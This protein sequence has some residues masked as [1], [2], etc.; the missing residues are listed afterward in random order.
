MLSC[1]LTDAAIAGISMSIFNEETNTF[2]FNCKMQIYLWIVTSFTVL[3][4]FADKK[5]LQQ[6]YK[7]QESTMFDNKHRNLT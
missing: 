5:H 2:Y 4:I 1:E 6:D 7:H 3:L